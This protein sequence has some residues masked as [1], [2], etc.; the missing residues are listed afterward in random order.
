MNKIK[1]TALLVTGLLMEG[2]SV[3]EAYT[4]PTMVIPEQYKEASAFAGWKAATPG[5]PALSDKWWERYQDTQL[6][7][8]LFLA[9]Q[10]NYSI[11]TAEANYRQ[12]LALARASRAPLLPAVNGQSAITRGNSNSGS[13]TELSIGI[14]AFWEIDLWGRIRNSVLAGEANAEATAADLAAVRLSVQSALAQTYFQLRIL[15]SQKLLLD[16]TAQSFERSLKLTI[17]RYNVG[18]A[19]RTE[20][21][22]AETQLRNTRA[23]AIDITA[24]RAQL[25]HAIA[26]LV[27]KVPAELSIQPSPYKQITGI[28]F[29]IAEASLPSSLLE[30]RPDIAAAERRMALANA[31]IGVAR[32]ALFPTLSLGAGVGYSNDTLGNLLSLPNRVWSLGPAL[33]GPIF[34]NQL[35]KSQTDAAIARYDASVASYKL[36]VINGIRE[37]EDNMALL[38]ILEAEAL[39]QETAVK[40]AREAVEQTENRYRAGISEYQNVVIVQ[41]ALLNAE[42]NL[43]TITGRRFNASVALMIALGGAH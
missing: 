32:A 31:Q 25:E 17:N 22:Q 1:L 29:P 36:T 12:G 15:D 38:R 33:A 39:E 21:A 3:W 40:F 16:T 23:Q 27:G 35:R 26:V 4:R 20:I 6:T 14:S 18:L 2:C 41:S 13:N 42:R 10:A 11:Q 9:N 19:S 8:L 43:L 7:Q 37:V 5:S 24:A 34:D 30:R 28:V